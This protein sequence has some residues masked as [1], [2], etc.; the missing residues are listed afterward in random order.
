[1]TIR[2]SV[3][4][5]ALCVGA[6]GISF[7]TVR[8]QE[9]D[10]PAQPALEEVVVTALKRAENLQDVPASITALSADQLATLGF[11][12]PTDL[13]SQVP[14]LQATSVM[15]GNTPIFALRGVSMNDY[16]MNQSSP[17]ASYVDE[18]YKG[19]VALFGVQMFDLE[20]VEVLRGPQGTLYGKNTT[21]GAINFVTKKADFLNEGFL[22]LGAGN[23]N[24]GT[25][26]GAIGGALVDDRLAG[27]LAFTY[28]H[29]NG[30]FENHYAG[31]PDLE[32]ID[33][34]AVRVG[35]RY[36]PSDT[37]DVYLRL[38]TSEQNSANYGIYARPGAAGVG[39]GL[40]ALLNSFD[41]TL[42]PNTDYS[43]TGLGSYDI[44]SNYT[45]DREASSHSAALTIDW[46][47]SDHFTVTSITSWDEGD[48][49]VPEDT[50]G[51]PLQALEI[52]YH[53]DARQ[54]GEDLRLTS[55]LPGR[56]NFIAGA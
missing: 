47:A 37:L 48:L 23:Y 14:N 25:A 50:D 54:I 31:G 13:V 49:F 18:V 38:A 55:T 45:P 10:A 40:Y 17:I 6:A 41:P 32:A 12:S 33:E 24:R 8:A 4:K 43:R 35:L 34:Y 19:N 39:G 16:G 56:F 51:S 42:N 20:R 44:E 15:G 29:A 46:Q 21:G 11:R 26:E 30:W 52:D 28:S 5:I 2:A 53:N 9:A 22:T 27:R 7:T 3:S 36:Q 1:M